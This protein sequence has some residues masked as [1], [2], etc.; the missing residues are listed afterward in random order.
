MASEFFYGEKTMGVLFALESLAT[1]TL[2]WRLITSL[3]QLLANVM[4][5][6]WSGCW[7]RIRQ[8]CGREA[9]RCE[10]R[11]CVFPLVCECAFLGLATWLAFCAFPISFRAMISAV[12]AEKADAVAAC[13]HLAE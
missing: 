13:T 7:R 5:P 3:G 11:A 9:P 1:A 8:A 10:R 4:Q 6:V 12:R 2:V